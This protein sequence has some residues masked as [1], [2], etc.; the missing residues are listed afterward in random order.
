MK[1]K[2]ILSVLLS[3]VM[4]VSIFTAMAIESYQAKDYPKTPVENVPKKVISIIKGVNSD[5]ELS[6]EDIEVYFYKPLKKNLALINYQGKNFA[7]TSEIYNAAIGDYIY[8]S[9]RPD[10]VKIIDF[11]KRGIYDI[12]DYYDQGK[13]N[14]KDLKKIAKYLADYP[15]AV[16][17]KPKLS[18]TK[19]NMKT[20]E[21]YKLKIK[22]PPG[23]F[24]AAKKWSSSDKKV[25][26]VNKNGKVTA[27]KKGKATITAKL[28]SGK[29]LKC[30]IT[31]KN[32]KK[33]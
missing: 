1:R 4:V 19:K 23:A 24:C 32:I 12:E 26:K 18:A 11:S 31:V 27:L 21:S 2:N 33:K 9:G 29:K 16:F 15:Q 30:K 7:Y 3:L 25:A 22:C 8:S 13:I 14:D 10:M 6:D 28:G 5:A 20:G 17:E